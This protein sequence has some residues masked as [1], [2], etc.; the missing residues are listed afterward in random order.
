MDMDIT[1]AAYRLIM[2]QFVDGNLSKNRRELEDFFQDTDGW[3]SCWVRC[4]AIVV[5]HHKRVSLGRV[6]YPMSLTCHRIGR[7]T[8]VLVRNP[9]NESVTRHSGVERDFDLCTNYSLVTLN[10]TRY[11]P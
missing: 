6:T 3:I 7:I 4:A 1:S 11:G 9:G 8:W 10:L 2:Q 5:Q